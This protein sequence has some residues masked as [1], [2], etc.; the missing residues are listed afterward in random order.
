MHLPF[1]KV[2]DPL[3]YRREYSYTE[4]V[5]VFVYLLSRS[6]GQ[7][8]SD[9]RSERQKEGSVEVKRETGVSGTP[10]SKTYK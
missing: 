8:Q 4:N 10:H 6:Q 3:H 7:V 5:Q 2:K 1:L 9:G